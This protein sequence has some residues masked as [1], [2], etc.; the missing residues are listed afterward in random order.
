MDWFSERAS[1][2]RRLERQTRAVG[3]GGA[4]GGL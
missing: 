1:D 2:L 4:Y 3:A